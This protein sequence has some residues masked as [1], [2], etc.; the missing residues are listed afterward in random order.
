LRLVPGDYRDLL[1]INNLNGRAD[2]WIVITGPLSGPPAIIHADPGPCCNTIEIDNSSYV[3]LEHLTI[4]GGGAQSD[5][6][7]GIEA[8]SG[9]VHHIRIEDNDLINHD[10]SQGT[11]AITTKVTT[12]GWVIRRNRIVRAGTG[13]YLGNPDGS[14]P[15]IGGLIENNLITDTIGYGMEIKWQGPRQI[16]EGMPTAPTKTI[17]RHNVF[18]KKDRPVGGSGA[19]PNLLVGG[20]PS[21]GPGSEDRYEIY[22]NLFYHNPHGEALIQASGRVSIHD[23]ILVD[24]DTAI[25]LVNHDLPLRQAYIY[26]NTIFGVGNGIRFSSSAPQGDAVVG[27]LV[28]ADS[29]ISG[30]ITDERDNIVDSIANA[31]NYINS[32]SLGLGTMD[33]YPRPGKAKG[34]PMDLSI[35]ASHTDYNLDFN[36]I[37]KGIFEFRGAYAGEGTNP[38]WPLSE[39]LKEVTGTTDM[40]RPAPPRDLRVR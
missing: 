27:N 9:K 2:A 19:R 35:F 14:A 38:G 24:A 12:W 34:T 40:T 39:T 25:L 26:N 32:P 4:D 15:F 20:F 6:A 36:G 3:A 28:F 10:G 7:F 11:D 5:G 8:R 22:G 29:P 13:L 30:S 37:S 33:F 23:N 1:R 18:I 16:V 21:S 17:I 31:G